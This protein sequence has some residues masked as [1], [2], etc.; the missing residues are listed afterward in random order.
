MIDRDLAD[1]AL[2]SQVG[3]IL[4]QASQRH[5]LIFARLMIEDLTP[6]QWAALAKLNE[7]GASS[8]S[9][10]GRNT[11]MDAATIKGVIDRLKKR[12][13]TEARLDPD[14]ARRLLVD[15]TPEGRA[16]YERAKSAAERI[17]IETL[18]PLNKAEQATFLSLLRKLV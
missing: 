12:N 4:R 15:L 17:T 13:L 2:E 5:T 9:Q 11:S 18:E 8:Q 10:L 1:Y 3:Y 7:L 14:D 16:M 6:T